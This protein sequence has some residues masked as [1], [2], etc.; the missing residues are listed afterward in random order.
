MENTSLKKKCK[1]EKMILK[2][3][4]EENLKEEES[5][6]NQSFLVFERVRRI[7][8]HYLRLQRAS[9]R[10]ET[11]TSITSEVARHRRKRVK[12]PPGPFLE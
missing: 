10:A 2:K 7:T 3:C 8:F 1:E 9:S 11:K 5:I 4:K 12:L 6:K